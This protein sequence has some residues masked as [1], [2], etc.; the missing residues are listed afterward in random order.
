MR[1]AFNG[2]KWLEAIVKENDAKAATINCFSAAE[3]HCK[4]IRYRHVGSKVNTVLFSLIREDSASGHVYE[5]RAEKCA[6]TIV[7][8][9]WA[10]VIDNMI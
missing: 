8:R 10:S 9:L 3:S 7:G 1:S 2:L 4:R 6:E 5:R